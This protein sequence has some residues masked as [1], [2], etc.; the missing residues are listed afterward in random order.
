ML[1]SL[2]SLQSTVFYDV[3]D[4]WATPEVRVALGRG[5]EDKRVSVLASIVLFLSQSCTSAVVQR[6]RQLMH[7]YVLGVLAVG[8]GQKLG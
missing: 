3:G 8:A 5:I 4:F 2:P 1:I 6:S 7:V